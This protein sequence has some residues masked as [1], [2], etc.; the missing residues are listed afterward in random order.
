MRSS[1][2]LKTIRAGREC[3]GISVL[4][5]GYL[6]ISSIYLVVKRFWYVFVCVRIDKLYEFILF[7]NHRKIDTLLHY[8]MH[9]VNFYFNVKPDIPFNKYYMKNIFLKV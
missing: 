9:P 7:S 4:K 1:W 2:V 3:F 5:Y 6:G 8:L